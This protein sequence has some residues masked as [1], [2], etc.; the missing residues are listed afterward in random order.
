MQH[1]K[2]GAECESMQQT[3]AQQVAKKKLAAG[4]KTLDGWLGCTDGCGSQ[5]GGRS[6]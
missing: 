1:G 3:E 5:Y 2:E 4:A 6:V